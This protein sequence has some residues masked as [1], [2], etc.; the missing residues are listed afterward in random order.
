LGTKNTK[1]MSEDKRSPRETALEEA[2]ARINDQFSNGS[3][4]RKATPEQ[5]KRFEA[6]KRWG[7]AGFALGATRGRHIIRDFKRTTED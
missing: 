4:L 6:R 5:L 1:E 2:L 3:I 7:K